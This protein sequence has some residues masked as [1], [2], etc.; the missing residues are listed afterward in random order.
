MHR[1]G[2][3]LGDAAA[4]RDDPAL[5]SAAE[6]YLGS[7]ANALH[8]AGIDSSLYLRRKWRK[9]QCRPRGIVL[10]MA[11]VFSSSMPTV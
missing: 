8:V 2:K 11:N 7:W 9:R 1:S 6:G 5:V 10:A 3:P 4:R